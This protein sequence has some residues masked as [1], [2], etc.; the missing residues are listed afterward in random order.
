[1]H[2]TGKSL[3]TNEVEKIF[4]KSVRLQTSKRGLGLGV[5]VG[6]SIVLAHGGRIWADVSED[7]TRFLVALPAS[8]AA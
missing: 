4:E 1:V 6:R 3:H 8:Q 2:D 7:G 5:Y